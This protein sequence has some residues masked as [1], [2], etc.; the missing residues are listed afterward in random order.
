M[1]PVFMTGGLDLMTVKA[2]AKPGTLR[3]CL[4]FEV[5]VRDGYSRID[6]IARFDGQPGVANVKLWR[7]KCVGGIP[8]AWLAGQ[9]I[10]FQSTGGSGYIEYTTT[11]A[12]G[13]IIY[14]VFSESAPNPQLPETI[15]NNTVAATIVANTRDVVFTSRGYQ[16]TYNANLNSL[17]TT[18]K[19]K[20]G[21]VP[22]RPGSDIIGHFMFKGFEY[23]IRDLYRVSF[24]G[25]YYTDANEG[26]FVTYLGLTYEILNVR[27][28]GIEQGVLTLDPIPGGVANATPLTA[29]VLSDIAITGSFGPG[30]LSIPYAD[31]LTAGGVPPYTWSVDGSGAQPDLTT[32]NLNDINFLP[33]I[34]D[35]ALYVALPTGWER[36]ELNR[37]MAFSSGAGFLQNFN[38]NLTVSGVSGSVV[39]K[40]PTA[41]TFNGTVVTGPNADDGVETPITGNNGD[42]LICKGFDFTG[43]PA[44]AIIKGIEVQ[45]ERRSN[46]G[47]A[48]KDALVDLLV[49]NGGTDNKSRS[50]NWP[51]AIA[52]VTYGGPTDL[53]G[54]QSITVDELKS[55]SFGVRVLNQRSVPATAAIGAF[56]YVR[57]SVFFEQQDLPIFIWNGTLD[58]Q[59]TLQHILTVSGDT[60][61][62]DAAGFLTVS[63]QQNAD[64]PR[65]IGEGDQVRSGPN[66]T[67]DLLCLVAARDMP[68]WLSGQAEMD[69][70][71]AQYVFEVTNFYGQDQFEAVFGVNGAGLA[72]SFDG[73]RFIR[74][75]TSLQATEDLPRHITRHGDCLVLGYFSGAALFSAVGD[76]YEMRG[77]EGATAIEVGDRMIAL[78]PLTGDALLIICQSS[79]YAIRGTTPDTFF[80]SVISAHRGGIEYTDADLGRVILCDGQ[81]ILAADSPEQF[82][83]A[84]R[85]YLSQVVLPWL[86]PRLQ[87]TVNSEQAYVRPIVGLNVRS[88]N[89]YRLYFWDGYVL[90]MTNTEPPQFTL[91][92]MFEPAPNEDTDVIPWRVRAVSS[93]IDSSG[94]ERLFVSFFGGVKEGFLFEMDAGRSFD[95]DPIPSYIETNPIDLRD[96]SMLKRF[97]RVFVY[98]NGGGYATVK[99]SRNINYQLANPA[100]FESFL[101]GATTTNSVTG[102]PDNDVVYESA[103]FRGSTDFPIEGD[104]V[105]LRFDHNSAVEAPFSLQ[106]LTLYTDARGAGRGTVR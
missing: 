83:A 19:A 98:G 45:V 89:Q 50:A 3:D 17:Y 82:G 18:E 94:R 64:K 52:A 15:T 100:Y 9:Q 86:R 10:T 57:I 42:E 7:L 62:G 69:N 75:H 93:G 101:M 1:N 71:G 59:M 79:T 14:A 70:N 66:G 37:E 11:N 87:A 31:G 65:L 21:I 85:N 68:N 103:A 58:V 6:G 88:K 102:L 41:S 81:G 39:N 26:Q 77:A 76:P 30:Y 8:S 33:Q 99:F 38:R 104:A 27:S 28:T 53:W 106:Y 80:R 43:I 84:A 54:S 29:A 22:G 67:G 63:G 90:T 55:S 2:L 51:N 34:T 72:W 60:T 78:R 24:Q 46:T 91:Q 44:N 49:Q 97:D 47:F 36:L 13:V 56:D 35:A 48:A 74:I 95:G 105:E 20:I 25:G 61:T 5:G 32:T 40:Y 73:E 12:E 4:N 96:P 23:A 92:R 16:S